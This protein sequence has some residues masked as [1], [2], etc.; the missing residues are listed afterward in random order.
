MRIGTLIYSTSDTVLETTAAQGRRHFT[1]TNR[2]LVLSTPDGLQKDTWLVSSEAKR[3]LLSGDFY[4]SGTVIKIY[5]SEWV[6]RVEGR[7]IYDVESGIEVT[8]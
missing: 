5:P 2:W 6:V 8:P 4:L 7:K 1:K 3:M